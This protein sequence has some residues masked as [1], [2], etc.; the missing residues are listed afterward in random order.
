MWI[1]ARICIKDG[2]AIRYPHQGNTSSGSIDQKVFIVIDRL[3]VVWIGK[4]FYIA[5]GDI[6]PAG[7]P[8]PDKLA[9]SARIHDINGGNRLIC[10]DNTP[11]AIPYSKRI[12]WLVTG[13]DLR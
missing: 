2:F 7:F 4:P 8:K 12:D 10:K 6:G 11:D 13:W 3:G 5:R 9:A 1:L